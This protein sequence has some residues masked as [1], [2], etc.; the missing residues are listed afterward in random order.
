MRLLL[1]CA[2]A[3]LPRG[4]AAQSYHPSPEYYYQTEDLC[5]HGFV[6]TMKRHGE[7][8]D[9]AD[10]AGDNDRVIT[11]TRVM[12]ESA[13]QCLDN[14]PARSPSDPE[15]IIGSGLMAS[16]ARIAT[17]QCKEPDLMQPAEPYHTARSVVEIVLRRDEKI[18][19][20]S[21]TPVDP[22]KDELR[23]CAQRLGIA[24]TF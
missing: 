22:Y 19:A 4:V 11:L 5:G 3:L 12:I 23:I 7:E 1:V 20:Y 6:L 18:F 21:N 9:A 8:V 16:E 14:L 13:T 2:L 15:G 24:V 10:T 17:D